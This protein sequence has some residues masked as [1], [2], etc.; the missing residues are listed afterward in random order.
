MESTYS[1]S[2]VVGLVSSNRRL[3]LP[4]NS[5]ATPKFRQIDFAWPMC[6]YPF[7]SG[8][9]R[10]ATRPPCLPARTSSAMSVRMKSSDSVVSLV[11]TPL[12]SQTLRP[13]RLG[14]PGWDSEVDGTGPILQEP[15]VMLRGDGLDL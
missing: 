11:L 5:A 2:S 13:S 10:V 1:T 12:V 9:K 8:G 6:R 15:G 4:A 14:S 7:G 3:Q